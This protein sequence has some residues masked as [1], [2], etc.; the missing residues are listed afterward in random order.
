MTDTVEVVFPTPPQLEIIKQAILSAIT[1]NTTTPPVVSS[2]PVE[3]VHTED[4]PQPKGPSSVPVL[5]RGLAAN[6][7][8]AI[9]ASNKTIR[10]A[11]DS[12]TYVGMA[13]F[14]AGAFAGQVV[15]AIRTAVRAILKALGLSPSSTGLANYLEKIAHE[16][17]DIAKLISKIAK[18]IQQVIAY[19]NA[20]KSLLALI[21]NLPAELLAYFKDCINTIKKQ[22]VSGY[23]SAF[24]S[25]GTTPSD[26]E[27]DNLGKAISDVQ[28]SLTQFNTAVKSAAT[29]SAGLAF[30]L[31]TPT[32]I[33]SGNTQAQAAATQAVFAAAGYSTSSNSFSKP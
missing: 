28:T 33:N 19:I 22:L 1:S 25:D 2:K 8:T 11:C 24:V 12:S 13:V 18:T 29:A 9:H 17:A 5:A 21:L 14:Q 23:K 6:S 7:D 27:V 20:L 31:I 15:N 26:A 16:V 4:K 10:H 30:S 3:P 32:Q